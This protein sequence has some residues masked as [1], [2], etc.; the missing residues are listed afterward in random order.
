MKNNTKKILAG[1]CLGLIGI[2]CLTGCDM[3]A[4]DMSKWEQKADTLIEKLD[5]ANETTKESNTLLENQLN[6]L[7]KQEAYDILRSAN[8]NMKWL[9]LGDIPYLITTNKENSVLVIPTPNDI[10]IQ[11][12]YENNDSYFHK[13]DYENEETSYIYEIMDNE[14][15]VYELEDYLNARSNLAKE[16][17]ESL[18]NFYIENILSYEFDENGVYTFELIITRI[19][20]QPKPTEESVQWYF[21][22]MDYYTIK[23]KD[24]R[25]IYKKHLNAMCSFFDDNILTDVAGNRIPDGYGSYS[26]D[27]DYIYPEGYDEVNFV[28]GEDVDSKLINNL[29]TKINE[30]DN[31]IKNGEIVPASFN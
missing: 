7:T 9:N 21:K 10:V 12:F 24:G 29:T 31:K 4:E 14:E 2:G 18:P 5:K 27:K 20:E 17:D 25:F 26:I 19:D 8:N 1:I 13:L 30:V 22:H 3:S 6:N 15:V 11:Y 16:T 28:Y 23:I